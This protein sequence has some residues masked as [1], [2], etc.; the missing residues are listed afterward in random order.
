MWLPANAAK[1]I[2]FFLR[3]L[4]LRV[5]INRPAFSSPNTRSDFNVLLANFS[6]DRFARRKNILKVQVDRFFNITNSFVSRVSLRN[7]A[8]Q[9]RDRYHIAAIGFLLKNYRIFH[10]RP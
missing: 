2:Q 4:Q 1:R 9:R 8:R 7:T 10:A 5:P 3:L 6:G